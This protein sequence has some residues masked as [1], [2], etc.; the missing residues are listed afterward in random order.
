MPRRKE[1]FA[2]LLLKAP[3][4]V[5]T[6]LGALAFIL[7]LL[8][9]VIYP[10]HDVVRQTFAKEISR[11]APLALIFFGILAVG[12]FWFGKKR[13]RLVDQ[14]ISLQSLQQTSWKDFEFLIAEVY[15]R[16]GY[17]VDFSLG[18]GADGGVDMVLRK[19]GRKS[20]VQCK[21]WK[22]YSVGAPVIRE[23][24]GLMTAENADEAVIV[25]TGRFTAEAQSFASG[26]PIQLI[27]GPQLLSLVQSVQATTKNAKSTK[28]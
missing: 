11:L 19:D 12:A 7:M 5:S 2:E 4:W 9:P 28:A 18:R 6:V 13:R 8:A 25:T 3:W 20:L 23:M 1:S 22:V 21:R 17:N 24:F 15:R 27:D 16:Q 10:A 14:Q 26:K